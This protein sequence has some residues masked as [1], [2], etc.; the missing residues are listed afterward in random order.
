MKFSK[1]EQ[2]QIKKLCEWAKEANRFIPIRDFYACSGLEEGTGVICIYDEKSHQPKSV[3][4][5]DAE[6]CEEDEFVKIREYENN[7][8]FRFSLIYKLERLGLITI[9]KTSYP[10]ADSKGWA[11][12]EG[13]MNASAIDVIEEGIGKNYIFLASNDKGV[14]I[15]EIDEFWQLSIKT[16]REVCKYTIREL[17][18]KLD[19]FGLVTSVVSIEQELFEL[20]SNGFKTYEDIQLEEAQNQ[21]KIAHESL[22]EARKQTESANKSLEEARKQTKASLDSLAETIKQTQKTQESL[23]EAQKQSYQARTQTGLSIFT[24]FLSVGAILWSIYASNEI[25]IT[26]NQSQF[27]SIQIQQKVLIETLNEIKMSQMDKDSVIKELDSTKAKIDKI[28]NT[29][30]EVKELNS[31]GK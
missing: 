25:P 28:S 2:E 3:L 11:C 9:S 8:L 23:D 15:V 1:L 13:F 27:D 29:L 12:F 17:S 7:C 6:K 14:E 4:Y 26:I 5:V 16:T 10:N 22:E 18:S 24:L 19:I 21:T 30:K 20:V 31:K